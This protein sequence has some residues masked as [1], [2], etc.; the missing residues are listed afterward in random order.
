[1]VTE[2]QADV[3]ERAAGA[4]RAREAVL[5]TFFATMSVTQAIDALELEAEHG[6]RWRSCAL[7]AV[8]ASRHPTAKHMW[9]VFTCDLSKLSV[10]RLG[11][12]L[13]AHIKIADRLDA[14]VALARSGG[15]STAVAGP[16]GV[17]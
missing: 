16:V 7:A 8:E 5:R 17:A 15:A 10:D 2:E 12:Y 3:L 1:M 6:P 9:W 13:T 4:C 14:L 11:D